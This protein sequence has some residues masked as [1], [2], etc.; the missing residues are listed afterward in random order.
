MSRENVEI[1]KAAYDAYNR[2]DWDALLKVVAPGFELDFSR[3]LG[4]Y[5][6]VF[7]LDRRLWD[8]VRETWE[9]DRQEP[10]E[11]IEAGDLVVVPSTNHAKGRG[12]IEVASHA[13]WVWTIRNGAIVRASMYQEK[14]DA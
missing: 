2:K 13:T 14:E 7:G 3:A 11:F 10:H 12:G 6:G 8:E 5:R 1:V 4:P 9:S